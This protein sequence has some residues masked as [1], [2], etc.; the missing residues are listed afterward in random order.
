[1]TGRRRKA[2]AQKDSMDRWLISYADFI[3]LLMIF[4]VL[5]YSFSK[6]DLEKYYAMADSLSIVFT[7]QT[8]ENLETSGAISP[9]LSGDNAVDQISAN[10]IE[11][12]QRQIEEFFSNDVFEAVESPTETNPGKLADYITVSSQERGLVISLK[13]T[14]LFASGSDQLNP[15]ARKIIKQLGN[16]LLA[17]PNHIRVEGHT[18]NLPIKNARIPSNWELST[19]RATTV[20]HVLQGEVGI[21]P[22]RLSVSGYGEYRPLV[23]NDTPENRAK[24]RRVDIVILKQK[25]AQF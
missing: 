5:M 25:Y 16:S 17:I 20:L 10:Q 3:T 7:G 18:D 6:M 11:E 13:D 4:F 22:E 2:E 24:N 8:L 21:P 23:S 12:I 14:L 19:L 15:E 1:L 9:G